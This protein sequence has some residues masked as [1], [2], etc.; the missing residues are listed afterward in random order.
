MQKYI[1]SIDQGTTSTRVIL[2]DQNL[3]PVVQAQKEISQSYPKPGWVE[4]NPHEIWLSVLSCMSEVFIRANITPKQI[5]SIAITNQRETTVVWEKESFIAIYPAIVWQSR[6]SDDICDAIKN[7]GHEDWITKKTG[8]RVDPYFSA[9]KIRWILDHVDGAQARAEKGE[10]LFGTMDSYILYRLSGG[11]AHMSDYSNASR[12]LLYNIHDLCWDDAILDVFNIPKQ[13]LPEVKDS[14]S[15]Y[16]YTQKPL[17]FNCSVPIASMIGDQQAALFGQGCFEKGMCKN[18]YGTGCFVLMNTANQRIESKH[19]LISSLAW[20][21]DG[22]VEYVLEGSIFVAGSGIQ[23]LRDELHFFE[24][25]AQSESLVRGIDSSE[26][27]IVVPSFVGLGAPYWNDKVRGA[28][29]NLTRGTSTAHITRAM[30]ESIAYQSKDVIDAMCKDVQIDHAIINVDG[31]VTKNGYLMQFQS[32]ILQQP[33]NLAKISE[34]TALGAC[35]LA[36]LATGFF[37]NKKE[38]TQKLQ[39][40]KV[41]EVNMPKQEADALYLEWRKVIEVLTSYHQG[42]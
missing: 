2:F 14:S 26:G 7:A 16:A 15:I 42:V 1:M 17:F 22:Q 30:L 23:W 27:V 10:L 21:I 41:Y 33:I 29:F 40:R 37:E 36:G 25:A 5:D 6:Q 9:S 4:Q 18:T 12:T 39:K 13:M 8:L 20:G 32:D 38:L 19:G 28:M 31:G 11:S 34:T 24:D 3:Q 35:M